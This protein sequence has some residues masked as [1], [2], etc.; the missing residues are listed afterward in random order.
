M[1]NLQMSMCTPLAWTDTPM[2][3]TSM[4]RKIWQFQICMY[5]IL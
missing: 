3:Q 4:K 5:K 2:R 1:Q